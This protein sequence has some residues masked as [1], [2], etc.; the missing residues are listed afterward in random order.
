MNVIEYIESL[1]TQGHLQQAMEKLLEISKPTYYKKH[2]IKISSNFTAYN[3]ATGDNKDSKRGPLVEQ[4]QNLLENISDEISAAVLSVDYTQ[5]LAA[6]NAASNNN[7]TTDTPETSSTSDSPQGKTQILFLCA[8]PDPD[9]LLNFD[10]EVNEIEQSLKR[11]N[12]R[13]RF[14][15]R[16]KRGVTNKIIR[17]SL[18]DYQP[19][20]VH[21]S[22][23]GAGEDGIIV[24]DESDEPI[25]LSTFALDV[26]FEIEKENIQC[27]I[28]NACYSEEQAKVIKKHIPYVIG[29]NDAIEDSTA[30]AFSIG[31]YEALGDNKSYPEAFKYGKLVIAMDQMPGYDIPQLLE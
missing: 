1:L 15:F 2:S 20:I 28:L 14:D 8:N 27:V 19:E 17:E 24:L 31:F 13:D 6:I 23:H 26:L 5:E 9:A 29:M 10:K 16:N 18:R 3:N 21:F 4:M 30:R 25:V 12:F 11:A 7:S 22:G